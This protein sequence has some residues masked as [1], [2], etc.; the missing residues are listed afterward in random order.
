MALQSGHH[1]QGDLEKPR[2]TLLYAENLTEDDPPYDLWAE[3]LNARP[4]HVLMW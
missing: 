4:E 1:S 2:A 3:G